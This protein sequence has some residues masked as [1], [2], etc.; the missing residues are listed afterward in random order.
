[1]TR[2]LIF[3]LTLIVIASVCDTINQLCLKFSINS[4]NASLSRDVMKILRFIFK[5]ALIPRVWVG[6]LFSTLSLCIWLFVLSR[7]DLNFAF[8]VDSMHYI[9]I[10]F[11]SSL[12]LKEKVGYKRWM[13]T[14]LILIG[15]VMVSLG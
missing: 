11:A 5:L 15:I 1:M 7:T 8:S 14:I 12:F 9:F 3:I 6:L 13:G 10:A 4:L 2:N